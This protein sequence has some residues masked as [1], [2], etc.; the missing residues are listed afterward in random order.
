MKKG[1]VVKP[2][3]LWI[4]PVIVAVILAMMLATSPMPPP[5][6]FALGAL[7]AVLGLAAGYFLTF[8]Q[9]FSLDP[10][11]GVIKGK[12]SPLGMILFFGLFA[13]RFAFKL[14]FMGPEGESGAKL[15]AHSGQIMLATDAMLVFLFALV[16]AQGWETWRRIKLLA[17]EPVAKVE[18]YPSE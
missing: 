5:V 15:A 17:A 2:S 8:H 9:H 4:R 13:A 10:A 7:A 3:R 18:V 16:A 6:G 12:T 14:V 1:R 11:T